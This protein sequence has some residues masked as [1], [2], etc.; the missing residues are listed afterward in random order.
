M[1]THVDRD[2]WPWPTGRG[3]IAL[4]IYRRYG[5][6]R[7]VATDQSRQATRSRGWARGKSASSSP[8]GRER[9]TVSN[10]EHRHRC[11]EICWRS[12]N[13]LGHNV[14]TMSPRREVQRVSERIPIPRGGRLRP[15]GQGVGAG[16][17]LRVHAGPAGEQLRRGH[18]S[19]IEAMA[20]CSERNGRANAPRA[21]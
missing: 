7:A 1:R 15:T 3:K 2:L 6:A 18:G 5:H 11:M 4:Q 8:E 10:R 17:R 16:G 21:M 19:W 9:K 13:A 12:L 20:S 14:R